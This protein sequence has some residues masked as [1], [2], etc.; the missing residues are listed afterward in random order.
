MMN[1]GKFGKLGI[2]GSTE[3]LEKQAH[4]RQ[5]VKKWGVWWLGRQG[6]RGDECVGKWG[7]GKMWA[8]MGEK[9]Q[10]MCHQEEEYH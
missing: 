3:P 6:E 9:W 10:W 8:L 2:G 5:N 1:F 4:A 7:I